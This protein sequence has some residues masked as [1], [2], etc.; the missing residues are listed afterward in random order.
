MLTALMSEQGEA[1]LFIHSTGT[2]PFM[3][4]SVHDAVI[5]ARRRLL[6][7]NLGYPPGDP[8]ERGRR[9]TAADDA[10]HVLGALSPDVSRVH[11]VA[12][13]YG[14]FVALHTIR[15]LGGRLASA[16]FYEPVAFRALASA[17]E[18]DRAALEEIRALADHPWFLH[19][20]ER[21]GREEWQSMFIDYWNRPGAWSAMPESLRALTLALGWKM[22]Q[23]VRSCFFDEPPGGDWR[24]P[25]PLTVA[26]GARTTLAARAMAKAL[27]DASR[28]GAGARDVTLVEV[29]GI[30]HMAP[31]T[32]AR[33]VHEELARHLARRTDPGR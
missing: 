13:S 17:R 16:F 1:V 21:G 23:E 25:A 15:A 6:P 4:A 29:P 9:V 19:D 30:G 2:G 11:L 20:E 12:H 33:R 5:G 3:W 18:P 28:G 26:Y 27:A 31:L 7:T 14:A 32:D 24:V 8:I 22:F 10:A